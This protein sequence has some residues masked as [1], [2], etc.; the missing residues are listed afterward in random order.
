MIVEHVYD[1][2]EKR[3]NHD[4][5]YLS[6]FIDL[7][8]LVIILV[9]PYICIRFWKI[10]L[11]YNKKVIQVFV[12]IM[13]FLLVLLSPFIILFIL[14]LMDW[15]KGLVKKKQAKLLK[16][17]VDQYDN[18]LK[19]Y[20]GFKYYIKAFRKRPIKQPM[21]N[22]YSDIKVNEDLMT[23]DQLL[24]LYKI[25]RD[26]DRDLDNQR[27][28]LLLQYLGFSIITFGTSIT[29]YGHKT[30]Y[31]KGRFI[32]ISI[33]GAFVSLLAIIF[34]RMMRRTYATQM[35]FIAQ[36]AKIE[37]LL[38]FNSNIYRK[39]SYWKNDGLMIPNHILG[40]R[41]TECMSDFVFKN[42]NTGCQIRAISFLQNIMFYLG[43]F[44]YYFGLYMVQFD[45]S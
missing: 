32:I 11:T 44:I 38:G 29:I 40:R 22:L 7:I 24:S 4:N 39:T 25:S 41:K 16:R 21:E 27:I 36:S 31:G 19:D 15:I 35:L 20:E 9:L 43:L 34:Y 28:N 18:N 33:C 1:I 5:S 23:T 45:L 30:N 26:T 6:L 42:E 12:R 14:M 17:M 3:K 10:P 37:D 8:G 2:L 13:V